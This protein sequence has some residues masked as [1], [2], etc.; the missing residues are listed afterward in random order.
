MSRVQ[1]GVNEE[2]AV[3]AQNGWTMLALLLG[4]LAADIALLILAER[5]MKI[6][7]V[8]VIPVIVTCLA[9]LFSLQPN[10]ARVLVLFGAY[11]GTV[12][13][14]GFHWANPFYSNGPRALAVTRRRP[15]SRR[16]RRRRRTR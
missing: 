4:A 6:V 11:K 1:S 13:E 8:L 2:R 15:A 12:R 3:N 10:E 5:P 7:F 16:P 14:S 9:G